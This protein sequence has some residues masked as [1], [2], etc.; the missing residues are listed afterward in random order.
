M[1]GAER[2]FGVPAEV[3]RRGIRCRRLESIEAAVRSKERRDGIRETRRR[4]VSMR[5]G[6]ARRRCLWCLKSAARMTAG[7]SG[8]ARLGDQGDVPM[9]MQIP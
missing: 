5:I 6:T 2:C 7:A 1:Y 3:P 8:R 9:E 4:R